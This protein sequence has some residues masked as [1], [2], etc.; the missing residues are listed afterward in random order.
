MLAI[1]LASGV[2]KKVLM[3]EDMSPWQKLMLEREWCESPYNWCYVMPQRSMDRLN[4]WI[5][6]RLHAS[7]SSWCHETPL[8]TMEDQEEDRGQ[9][10]LSHEKQ[11][12]FNSHIKISSLHFQ[13]V[14]F[15][16]LRGCLHTVNHWKATEDWLHF[17]LLYVGVAWWTC[18]QKNKDWTIYCYAARYDYCW[19]KIRAQIWKVCQQCWRTLLKL[20]QVCIENDCT[21]A[22]TNATK[23]KAETCTFQGQL[24]YVKITQNCIHHWFVF[25][26]YMSQLLPWYCS[27]SPIWCA[28]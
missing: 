16:K 21:V 18:Y 28:I 10:H 22:I 11:S 8:E 1:N 2:L 19:Q 20:K 23:Y 26:E 12:A 5:P 25:R 24:R 17:F 27:H 14:F 6:S 4:Y 13:Y 9:A 15:R 7:C 3:L